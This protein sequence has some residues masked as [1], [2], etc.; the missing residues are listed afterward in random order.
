MRPERLYP[1]AIGIVLIIVGLIGM[2]GSYYL[3]H[4]RGVEPYAVWGGVLFIGVLIAGSALLLGPHSPIRLRPWTIRHAPPTVPPPTPPA[5]CPQQR[6]AEPP[7]H[8]R[9][10]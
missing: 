1:L 7:N 9:I 4:A 2:S 8:L 5:I 6:R 10:V 3:F